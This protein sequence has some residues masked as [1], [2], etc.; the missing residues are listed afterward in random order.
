VK[1]M[2]AFPIDWVR[3]SKTVYSSMQQYS[4]LDIWGK[5]FKLATT[6]TIGHKIANFDCIVIT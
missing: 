1:A 2:L 6:N 5:V 4:F 3:I